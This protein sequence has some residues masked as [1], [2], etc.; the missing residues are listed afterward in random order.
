MVI[1][2]L[3]VR[4]CKPELDIQDDYKA[5]IKGIRKWENDLWYT[6]SN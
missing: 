5:Q 4:K 6:Q 1:E 3:K 2:A